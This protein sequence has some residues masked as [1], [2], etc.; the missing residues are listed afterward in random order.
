MTLTL[1][2]INEFFISYA[3]DVRCH[4]RAGRKD[5]ALSTYEQCRIHLND[6]LAQYIDAIP[7]SSE[8]NAQASNIQLI[9]Q[10]I[11]DLGSELF[12]DSLR[13]GSYSS[14]TPPPVDTHTNPAVQ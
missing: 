6:L 9:H 1:L 5:S 7:T 11:S 3:T 2:E 14:Y 12:A 10:R 4:L 8:F 13:V